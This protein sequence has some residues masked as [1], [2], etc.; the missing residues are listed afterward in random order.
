MSRRTP[1]DPL[2][3][4]VE[5][6]PEAR[7]LGG[8]WTIVATIC[9]FLAFS[10][11]ARTAAVTVPPQP[12]SALHGRKPRPTT[13]P[14]RLRISVRPRDSCASFPNSITARVA[15]PFL[16]PAKTLPRSSGCSRPWRTSSSGYSRAQ[17]QPATPTRRTT[18]CQHRWPGPLPPYA[19][20][21]ELIRPVWAPGVSGSARTAS[22]PSSA[23]ACGGGTRWCAQPNCW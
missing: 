23:H 8:R 16:I 9:M 22:H 13:S 12:T 11:R 5:G 21:S 19:L 18:T 10:A 6:P 3:A 7:S 17:L 2:P 4:P 14:R 1:K 20:G 15:S